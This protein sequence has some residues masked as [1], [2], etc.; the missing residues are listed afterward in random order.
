M[1]NLITSDWHLR[2]TVPSCIDAT[3]TEW[4]DIQRSALAKIIEIAVEHGVKGIYQCGDIFHSEVAT[5]FECIQMVQDFAESCELKG[6]DFFILAGN[7]DEKYHSTSNICRSAIGILFKSKYIKD[8]S[9]MDFSEIKGCNFDIEDYGDVE[10]IAK[11]VLC[12]PEEQ[13]PDFVECETPQTLLKKFPSAKRI[14]LG[15]YHRKFAYTENGRFVIN[16]GCLTKQASD[17]E[18]YETGVF[19]FDFDIDDVKWCPV[20]IPQKFV[21]N[22]IKKSDK[23]VDDFINGIKKE[24]ITLD[25]IST[26]KKESESQKKNIKQKV[27]LWIKEIGQ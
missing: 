25:F 18:D 23:T 26:L 21:K 13:K 19:V 5:S 15:D 20:N 16:P 17:F 8:M 10:N 7:H 12:I 11:H 27:D 4:M 2:S 24:S 1:K 3:P 9:D 6:I 22:A 14:F